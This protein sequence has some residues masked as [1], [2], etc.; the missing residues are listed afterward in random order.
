MLNNSILNTIEAEL[1]RKIGIA[2][3]EFELNTISIKTKMGF[4]NKAEKGIYP[5]KAPVGY[6]N[7]KINN[8]PK[9]T[10]DPD[11]AQYVKKAYELCATGISAKEI[12]EKLYTEGFRTRNG[13][14]VPKSSIK[15]VL[16]NPFYFGKFKFEGIMYDGVHTPIISKELFDMVQDVLKKSNK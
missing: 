8:E 13:K 11:N 14:K 4:K 9:I 7:I 3:A 2:M 12:A 1:M 15:A 16:E 10:I 5:H 6:K